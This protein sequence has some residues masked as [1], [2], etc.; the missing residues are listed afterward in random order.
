MPVAHKVALLGSVRYVDGVVVGF[1]PTDGLD[2]RSHFERLRPDMLIVTEDDKY[3][4]KKRAL[5]RSVG[6]DYVVLP[7]TL[8][9]WMEKPVSSSDI[10]SHIVAPDSVPLR[11]DFAGGWLDVPTHADPSS[12]VVNCTIAPKVTRTRWPY[13]IGG[14]IGGSAARAILHAKNGIKAELEMG[15]GWQDPAVIY[16]TGLCVWRARKRPEL[17]LKRAPDIL[18]RRMALAWTGRREG[19]TPDI[20]G[21]KRNYTAIAAAGRCA[22]VAVDGNSFDMLATAVMQ[23]YAAQL[24]EGMEPL[25]CVQGEAAK[26]YCG[27]GWGGYALYLFTKPSD[28]DNFLA[29]VGV[30]AIEPYMGGEWCCDGV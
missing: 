13:K 15:A 12:Y 10:I 22:A 1:D 3:E 16:E 14:G 28:R 17:V 9:E 19:T 27:A 25:A 11:V 21:K 5:C 26:K 8:P 7:K 29:N 30:G 18:I 4:A 20:C 24:D 23:S 6:A 2:F